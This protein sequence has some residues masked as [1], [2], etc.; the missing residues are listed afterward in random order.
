MALIRWEPIGEL[1]TIQS[2]MNR[3]FNTFFE[4][5]PGG[6]GSPAGRRW[7]PA[8]DL[9]ETG[10][11]F[12]LRADLPGLSEDD[13]KIELEGGVLTVSGERK[14]EHEHREQGYARLE[15]SAGSFAR[16]LTLPDGIDP[17]S[18]TASFDLGVL[19]V[20]IPKPEQSKPRKVAISVGG[21]EQPAIE[22]SGHDGQP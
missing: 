17:D 2:E 16:S 10:D 13:V 7:I 4:G 22:A 1:D 15:R 18:I 20:R 11:E 21:G 5:P 6:N 12:V 14:A 3:L 19:E 9:V 8:M